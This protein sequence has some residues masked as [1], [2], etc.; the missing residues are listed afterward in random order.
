[1]RVKYFDG[2][3]LFLYVYLF[4]EVYLDNL[5]RIYEG[6]KLYIIN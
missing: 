5:V 3:G 6:L 2:Y 4:V 1:M